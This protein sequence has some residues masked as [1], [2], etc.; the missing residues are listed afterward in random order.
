MELRLETFE[1][2]VERGFEH[3]MERIRVSYVFYESAA[4][5][6]LLFVPGVGRSGFWTTEFGLSF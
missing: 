4:S 5:S 1:E 2:K 6:R 3:L